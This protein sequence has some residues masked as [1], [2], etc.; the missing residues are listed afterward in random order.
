MLAFPPGLYA[1]TESVELAISEI[2]GNP[3]PPFS[4]DRMGGL[5]RELLERMHAARLLMPE[6]MPFFPPSGGLHPSTLS[7]FLGM[8]VVL[9]PFVPRGTVQMIG[10]T[11]FAN[12]RVDLINLGVEEEKP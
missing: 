4:E 7:P 10:S 9:D 2:L 1:A 3:S 8:P 6:V 5:I 12:N 11:V